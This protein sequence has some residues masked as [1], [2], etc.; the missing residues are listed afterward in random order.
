MFIDN[1]EHN[2]PQIQYFKGKIC[3]ALGAGSCLF[4]P[5]NFTN[6]EDYLFQ[7]PQA[8]GICSPDVETVTRLPASVV[9]MWRELLEICD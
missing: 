3:I 9:L 4:D 7:Q 8:V 2:H 1:N 6:K 5:F